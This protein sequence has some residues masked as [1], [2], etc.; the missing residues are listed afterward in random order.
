MVGFGADLGFTPDYGCGTL[1]DA[2]SCHGTQRTNLI[3]WLEG[4]GIQR[5]DG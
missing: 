4:L 5:S 3:E 1:V 2:A